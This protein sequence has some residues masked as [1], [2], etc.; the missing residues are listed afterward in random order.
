I[1]PHEHTTP[2]AKSDRLQML[3]S[4]RTNLSCIWGLTPAKGLTV[5]LGGPGDGDPVW[6]DDDGVEHSLWVI[7]D[8]AAIDAISTTVGAHPVVIADGHHRFETSVAYRDE[9]RAAD[10]GS[11][12]AAEAAMIYIVELVA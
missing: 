1:L 7:D 2:K 9:R 11:A 8:A 10:G 12:G 4:T 6:T 3:R 5:L